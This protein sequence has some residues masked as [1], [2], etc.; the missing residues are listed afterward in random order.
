MT[1][2]AE[3]G[4]LALIIVGAGLGLFLRHLMES[5]RRYDRVVSDRLRG[6]R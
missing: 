3:L 1:Y 2:K 4:V 5:R 6:I